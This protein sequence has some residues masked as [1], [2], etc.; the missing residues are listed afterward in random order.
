MYKRKI[1]KGF[2]NYFKR[3]DDL[4][5]KPYSLEIKSKDWFC[6]GYKIT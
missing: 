4:Y 5:E 2:Q 1:K 3:I 6:C